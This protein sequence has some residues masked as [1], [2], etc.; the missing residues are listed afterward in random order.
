MTTTVHDA[1]LRADQ[2]VQRAIR[3]AEI[4]RPIL[5][6]LPDTL[7]APTI[8]NEDSEF[9]GTPGAW[10]SWS[11]FRAEGT[12][13]AI[14]RALETAGFEPVPMTL[15]KWG[16]YRVAPEPGALE[17]IPE[18]K[19]R[20]TL[21]DTTIAAPLWIEPQ[22]HGGPEARAYYARDGRIYKVTVPAPVGVQLTARRRNKLGDWYFERPASIVFPE[23][24][25]RTALAGLD[26]GV[27]VHTRAYI[28]TPQGL[29]GALYF[30]LHAHDQTD[31]PHSPAA[32][33]AALEGAK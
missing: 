25:W 11:S 17:A 22:Q 20:D 16:Q 10:L 6:A 4:I 3:R 5:A 9:F 28:D 8:S 27:S 13:S 7:P 24:A 18:V 14:L 29:S 1:R 19:R 32:I 23:A 15:C 30:E 12:G 31:Y 33:L 21:T 2:D 26:L